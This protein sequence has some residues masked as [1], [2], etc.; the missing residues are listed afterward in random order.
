M[1]YKNNNDFCSPC[2]T[3]PKKLDNVITEHVDEV[4]TNIEVFDCV[5][6][7]E[8]CTGSMVF[9]HNDE[10]TNDIIKCRNPICASC[11]GLSIKLNKDQPFRCACGRNFAINN[12]K[13]VP[14]TNSFT[15]I[16]CPNCN[17]KCKNDLTYRIHILEKCRKSPRICLRCNQYIEPIYQKYHDNYCHYECKKCNKDIYHKQYKTHICHHIRCR[18]CNS[19]FTNKKNLR[20]HILLMHHINCFCCKIYHKITPTSAPL[21]NCTRCKKYFCMDKFL[22]HTCLL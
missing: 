17:A 7:L 20:N 3:F 12:I 22:H 5:F 8:K 15:N 16:T 19:T 2:K 14:D 18:D 11:I 1:E 6:C 13:A 9:L 4:N 21:A 10:I